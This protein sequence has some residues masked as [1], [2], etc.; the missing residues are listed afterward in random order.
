MKKNLQA[1]HVSKKKQ[2]GFMGMGIAEYAAIIAVA[3]GVVATILYP[4]I[5]NW[6]ETSQATK[7]IAGFQTINQATFDSEYGTRSNYTGVKWSDLPNHLPENFAQRAENGE[8]YDVTVNTNPTKFN[9]TLDIPAV[10]VMA[11]VKSRYD[12]T[13]YS[14]TGDTITIVGP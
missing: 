10:R 1:K 4:A 13:Q 11:R 7:I 12:S 5:R 6:Q 2:G 14:V 3:L 8:D 9:M